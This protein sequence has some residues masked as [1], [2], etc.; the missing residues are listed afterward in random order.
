MKRQSGRSGCLAVLTWPFVTLWMLLSTM[1]KLVGWILAFFLGL[2]LMIAGALLTVTVV[3]AVVGL[4][5]AAVGL[6][7]VMRSLF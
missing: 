6:L 7:L 3:G 5:L 2:L 1:I 4:P